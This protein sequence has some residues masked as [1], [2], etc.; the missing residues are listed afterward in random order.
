MAAGN[1]GIPKQHKLLG[2]SRTWNRYR[3]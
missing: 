1:F 3:F 2:I